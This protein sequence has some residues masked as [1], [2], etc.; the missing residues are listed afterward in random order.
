MSD[1]DQI[2]GGCVEGVECLSVTAPH[3]REGEP[4]NPP[5]PPHSPTSFDAELAQRMA[6]R[7][8]ASSRRRE[9]LAEFRYRLK[10][11]RI[12]GKAKL[13]AIKEERTR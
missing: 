8:S 1:F 13:H 10:Q 6:E 5:H 9:E 4:V 3:A 2:R 11:A 12:P 7:L